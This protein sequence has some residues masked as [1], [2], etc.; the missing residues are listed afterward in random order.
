MSSVLLPTKEEVEEYARILRDEVKAIPIPEGNGKT[1]LTFELPDGSEFWG[2][3]IYDVLSVNEYRHKISFFYSNNTKQT[4][5]LN[6]TN[7]L[8][9]NL[10]F[11]NLM[12]FCIG[13]FSEYNTKPFINERTFKDKYFNIVIMSWETYDKIYDYKK[14]YIWAG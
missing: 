14:K 1:Q 10:Q 13:C 3:Y 5:L 7:C 8:S 2:T 11:R 4:P 6:I 9:L 12:P